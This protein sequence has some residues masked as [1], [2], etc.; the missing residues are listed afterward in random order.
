MSE[1]NLYDFRL[2][3]SVV[4]VC[5]IAA[6]IFHQNAEILYFDYEYKQ[7][8]WRLISAHFVHF[9]FMHLMTNLIAFGLLVYLFP[10]PV[11]QQ[12]SAILLSV[13]VI[14]IYLFFFD[15]Q[16]YAGLSGL[17]YAIPGIGF[18]RCIKQK[19]FYK[20]TGIVI[21]LIIYLFFISPQVHSENF[22][23]QPLPQAHLIGFICGSLISIP[24]TYL[25]Q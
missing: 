23:W 24:R 1:K 22:A 21:S 16:I 2:F 5:I 12:I 4:V 8:A 6:L 7:E 17:V 10:A 13:L 11:Y 3:N 18:G 25:Y 9:D 20:A 15:I 14:D 19:Q